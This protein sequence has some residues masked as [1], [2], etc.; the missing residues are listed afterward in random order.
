[1]MLRKSFIIYGFPGAMQDNTEKTSPL[2]SCNSDIGPSWDIGSLQKRTHAW[3][4]YDWE[5]HWH[6]HQPKGFEP[7]LPL[8]DWIDMR[9]EALLLEDGFMENDW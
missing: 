8:L 4:W 7:E 2:I 1:M 9:R 6:D 5:E 3:S